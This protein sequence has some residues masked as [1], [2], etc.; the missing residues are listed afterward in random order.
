MSSRDAPP[1]V[2]MC[3]IFSAT[4]SPATW[5]AAAL[6]PP[7][8]TVKA[9]ESAM[10]LAIANVPAEKGVFSKKPIGP[11]QKMV[12]AAAKCFENSAIDFGPISRAI[13]PAGTASTLTVCPAGA[14]GARRHDD[15]DRQEERHAF[16][17]G[18]FDDRSR[19]RELVRLDE[20]RLHVLSLRSE[21]RVRHRSA[22][23]QRR[24]ALEERFDDGDLVA[25]F[26]A[27]E[28]GHVG[29]VRRFNDLAEQRD[30]LLEE[31]SAPSI[32]EQLG[33]TVN[34]RVSAVNGPE[35]V[36]DVHVRKFGE[37]AAKPFVVLLLLRMKA[38]I[39]EQTCVSRPQIGNDFLGGIADAI[40]GKRNVLAEELRQ[41]HGAGFE[42]VFRIRALLG[43][44]KVTRADD[45]CAAFEGVL[46]RRKRR[47]NAR[48]V[49]D[50][51]AVR[52]NVEVDP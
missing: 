17:L 36:V 52:G 5:T 45:A 13:V 28:Y 25:D 1:P 42:R 33:D 35:G 15:I 22:D 46:D 10:V 29:L 3:L 48:I 26:R 39:L 12:F 41:A 47:A 27:T 4:P 34:A 6:S 14:F 24:H 16:G 51:L 18:L 31:E 30:L 23:D 11:F 9:G 20:R 2:E 44:T 43:S 8:M 7:P 21:E 49:R 37:L 32:T 50:R 19:Q 38:E 40:L